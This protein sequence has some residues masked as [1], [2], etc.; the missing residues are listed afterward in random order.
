MVL[1]TDYLPARHSAVRWTRAC[2]GERGRYYGAVV[3]A[4]LGIDRTEMEGDVGGSLVNM[5]ET[6]VL[7]SALPLVGCWWSLN[8]FIY[9][10]FS[11]FPSSR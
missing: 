6:E 2:I 10:F 9:L 3:R 11:F 1:P 5:G 4:V 8:F 7:V